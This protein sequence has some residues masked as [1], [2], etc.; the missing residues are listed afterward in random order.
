YNLP[1]MRSNT[2]ISGSTF[3]QSIDGSINFIQNL[4]AF[5]FHNRG[6]I[7]KSAVAFNAYLD[8]N[9]NNKFDDFEIRIPDVD[10]RLSSSGSK[11]TNKFGS[12]LVHDLNSYSKINASL[13]GGVNNNPEWKPLND[14]FSFISDPNHYKVIDIPFYE[15]SEISGTVNRNINGIKIPV[16]GITI[17]AENILNKSIKKIK[18][19]SDGSFYYYGLQAG[20][21]DI[22]LDK[23]D[24]EK[25]KVI[26]IPNIL[27][28]QIKPISADI[29]NEEIEFLLEDK[30]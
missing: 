14:K 7:G 8:E 4:N 30:M 29:E 3:T 16:E 13:F 28:T 20:Q 15:A 11:Q 22:Y 26:S 21:Y 2:T 25:L 24:L 27:E 23:N 18:T 6:M 5:E 1:F 17:L 19:I 10:V 12:I 9:N